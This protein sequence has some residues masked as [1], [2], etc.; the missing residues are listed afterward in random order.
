MLTAV[1]LFGDKIPNYK[2][3]HSQQKVKECDGILTLGTSLEVYSGYQYVL[4]VG[5][6]ILKV[7]FPMFGISGKP[8]KETNFHREYWINP[9]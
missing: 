9:C 6:E 4:Q 1:T 2:L 8:T 5:G 3:E 7:R